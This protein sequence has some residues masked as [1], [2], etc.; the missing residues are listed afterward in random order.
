[1]SIIR[2]MPKKKLQV[3]EKHMSPRFSMITPIGT[4]R[5]M[6]N[7]TSHD[8]RKFGTQQVFRGKVPPPKVK[9]HAAASLC[10]HVA[11]G[12]EWPRV[13]KYILGTAK[14]HA[15][16]NAIKNVMFTNRNVF[17]FSKSSGVSPAFP[18]RML[19]YPWSVA[20]TRGC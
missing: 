11:S 6:V 8:S 19:E 1:M 18:S 4:T 12:D 7:N 17:V 3:R 10:W 16:D 9:A 5:R 15:Y 13:Y 14:P 20:D 2:T